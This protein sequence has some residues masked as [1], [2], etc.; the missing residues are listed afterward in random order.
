[1]SLKKI[2]LNSI[3]SKLIISL[4]SIAVI[5]LIVTGAF[6]YN[7]SK[8]IL[9][10]KL[11]LTST[12]TL[13]EVNHGLD[14]YLF[15]FVKMSN[16]ISE[17]YDVVN[18]DTEDNF[19]FISGVLKG[20]KESDQDI[21]DAYY[22]TVSGK[23]GI[24]PE[25]KMP[26]GYDA[27]TRPWYK[28]AIA[29]NGKAII[30][31]PYKDAGSGKMVIGV[32]KTVMKDGKAVG[33]IGFDVSLSTLAERIGAK[34]VGNSGYVFIA[35]PEGIIL[36][37]PDQSLIN[38]D[39]ASKLSFWNEA[40]SK[41]NG[42]VEYSYD[43]MNKFGV[44]QTDELTGWKMVASLEQKELTD[45]TKSILLTSSIIISIMAVIAVLMSLVLSKGISINIK[46][47]KEVFAKASN[48]DL[49]N[50]IEVKS[51]DEL[52]ELSRDYNTMID[53]IGVLLESA[54]KTSSVVLDT[55]SN[56]SAMA[57]ETTASM[58]QVSLAV[59][60]IAQGA[61]NLAENSQETATG[62]GQLSEGLDDVSQATIDM[63][64]VSKNTKE[65]SSQGLEAV[66]ILI[67]KN[68]ATTVYVKEVAEIVTDVDNSAK[69]IEI[70]SD[71]INAITEQT[72]LLSLNASIEAARAGEAGRGFSVVA[73]EIRKLAEQS[74]GS[75][76]Q[77]KL[78]IEAIQTKSAKA[79]DAMEKT[80]INAIDRNKAVT[81]TEEIF[82]E[83]MNSVTVLT[84]KVDK[85]KN[86]I[87][88]MQVQKQVFVA[89][90]ENTSAIS[91]ET[92]SST[93]EVTAST[94]EVTATMDQFSQHTVELQQLA[95]KLKEEIDKFKI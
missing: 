2:N 81:K 1:M 88:T 56:L 57:E 53:H 30:T 75:T 34:K 69:E 67:D 5:P 60:E 43:G 80:R 52:G 82:A 72:N 3:R 77:I 66:N 65:L 6:S 13:M 94:E 27:T 28:Q 73:D 68:N 51:K 44:Y 45:D 90:V 61:N 46:K 21:M 35:N 63:D 14:D 18:V 89:Q 20:I 79:V 19:K 49:S 71:T 62:I 29:G 93:E 86:S 78:I 85:V 59:S 41:S 76:E 32:A 31:E 4:V 42:F 8:S 54:K 58:S 11:T 38:T 37:H 92:A 91:E 47:L 25:T 95:E 12:Q 23:F 36:A 87:D 64:N 48:G 70:I 9:D 17:N 55:A 33:V 50:V 24:Y 10:K 7:Q 74:K 15:G 16:M 22:G 84:E 83:I 40:K 39:T 26:D